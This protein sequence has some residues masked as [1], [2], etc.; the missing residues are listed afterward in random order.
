MSTVRVKTLVPSIFC[1][2]IACCASAFG[3]Y[4]TQLRLKTP[5]VLPQTS[6][7]IESINETIEMNSPTLKASHVFDQGGFNAY[8]FNIETNANSFM[9]IGATFKWKD[10]KA[11]KYAPEIG[12][13]QFGVYLGGFTRFFYVPSFLKYQSFTGNLFTRLDLGAGPTFM[14][15]LAGVV[16]QAAISVGTEVYFSKWFGIGA[17]LTRHQLYGVETLAHSASTQNNYWKNFKFSGGGSS[18]QLYFKSTYF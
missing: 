4:E 18:F 7:F 13:N 11:S 16:G 15:S 12:S 17:S 14:S 5:F 10:S 3:S 8:G 1:L 6:F 2:W 9:N